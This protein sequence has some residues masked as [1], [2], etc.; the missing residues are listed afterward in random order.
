MSKTSEVGKK[1][2]YYFIFGTPNCDLKDIFWKQ[3]DV[4][5]FILPLTQK[6]NKLFNTNAEK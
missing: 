1:E 4:S 5:N 6:K 3:T 2:S